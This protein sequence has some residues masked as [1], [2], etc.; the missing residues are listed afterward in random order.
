MP[1]DMCEGD[2]MPV[3]RCLGVQGDVGSGASCVP[4]ET[5]SC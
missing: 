4:E 3:A 1:I 2:G 5:W